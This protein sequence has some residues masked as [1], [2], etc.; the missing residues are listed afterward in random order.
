MVPVNDTVAIIPEHCKNELQ[1]GWRG[2]NR[3]QA[4]PGNGL[5]VVPQY[6]TG[7]IRLAFVDLFGMF[8]YKTK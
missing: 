6:F 7:H 2:P 8:S 3:N 1:N 5:D 4:W